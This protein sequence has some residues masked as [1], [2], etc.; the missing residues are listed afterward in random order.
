[1]KF[2]AMVIAS[3][4]IDEIVDLAV[5]AEEQ[6]FE[7]FW[8]NDVD[9]L[10]RNPWP[11]FGILARETRHIKLGPCVTNLVT[12]PWLLL[13]GLLNSLQELSGGRMVLGVG[14]GDAAV[15]VC[16]QRSMSPQKFRESLAMLR[17]YLSGEEVPWNGVTLQTRFCAA[18]GVP[19][20]GA[21]YGPKVLRVVGEVCDGA[22][23]QSADPATVR[24]GREFV[25]EGTAS[26]QHRSP[27]SLTAAAPAYVDDDLKRA[28]DQV[29]W[30]AQVVG[31]HIADLAR[32]SSVAI[33]A[34][35]SRFARDRDPNVR[36]ARLELVSGDEVTASQDAVRRV[37]FVG[38]AETH[39]SRLRELEALGVERCTL[40]LNHD[41][42]PRTIDS[43]G[44][45]IIPI[46]NKTDRREELA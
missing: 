6:G 26:L 2:G 1:M 20:L 34:E 44:T 10:Y 22:I 46:I 41:A 4:E 7:S 45:D 19:V 28:C 25:A 43:Y 29:G 14:R 35:V 38:P 16:G 23:I 30:F 12:R 37:A 11:I 18:A 31:H 3:L 8:L 36:G 42:A 15:R 5:R 9:M 32:T 24:W 40:Y 21:G 13:A 17:S 27:V 39:L 33:P